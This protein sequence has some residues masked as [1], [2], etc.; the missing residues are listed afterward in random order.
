MKKSQNKL[1]EED[2]LK[3]IDK[4]LEYANSLS[5]LDIENTDLDKMENEIEDFDKNLREKYKEYL[6]K[7]DLD[8]KK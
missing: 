4:I 3:D 8:S 5:T 6:P 7:E 1:N 2:L